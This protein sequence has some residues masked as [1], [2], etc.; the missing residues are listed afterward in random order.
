MKNKTL[1]KKHTKISFRITKTKKNRG[2]TA[3]PNYFP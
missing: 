1:N 2:Q 3:I